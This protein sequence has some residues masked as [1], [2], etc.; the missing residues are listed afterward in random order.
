MI[1]D[2]EWIAECVACVACV[3]YVVFGVCFVATIIVL[4]AK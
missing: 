3:A 2:V 4:G 1:N